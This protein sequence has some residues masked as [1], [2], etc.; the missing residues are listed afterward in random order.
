MASNT[1]SVKDLHHRRRDRW[2]GA[3][4]VVDRGPPVAPVRA[5]GR[6]ARGSQRVVPAPLLTEDDVVGTMNVY[7]H[8][9]DACDDRAEQ[10]G[11]LFAVPAAIAV[12]NAQ[13]LAEAH[14]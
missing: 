9:S 12:Q 8:G 14:R 1:T 7:A 6:P 3:V 2:H 13:I 5:Q 4:R 11:E 10:L